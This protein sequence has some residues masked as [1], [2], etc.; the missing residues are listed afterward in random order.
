MAA[1]LVLGPDE[2][3]IIKTEHIKYGGM[4]ANFQDTLY[5]TNHNVIVEKK[6]VF[7][8]TKEII[9]FP[10]RD[11][12]VYNNQAQAQIGKDRNGYNTLDIYFINGQ[13]SFSFTWKKDIIPWIRKINELL[14]GDKVTTAVVND[15]L[16]IPGSE[17]VARAIKGTI[18]T[19]KEAFGIKPKKPR[20][21]SIRCSGCNASVNG[22][23]GTSGICP[24]CGTYNDFS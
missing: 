23:E 14:T 20:K 6:N 22:E 11:I 3:V 10:I 16:S 21:V 17:T 4:M 24:Y 1:K 19:Y 5:L 8:G 18:D 12:K 2:S 15:R 9:Y 13:E 7:G